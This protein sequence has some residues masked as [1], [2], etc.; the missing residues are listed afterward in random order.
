MNSVKKVKEKVLTLRN[1]YTNETVMTNSYHQVENSENGVEFIK[2][3]KQANPDRKY[4]VNRSAFE[5]VNK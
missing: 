4:L 3:Y 5:I 1:R 2:V